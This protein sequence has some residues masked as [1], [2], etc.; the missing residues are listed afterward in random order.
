MTIKCDMFL[1]DIQL[2][3][4]NLEA[5]RKHFPIEIKSRVLIPDDETTEWQGEPDDLFLVELEMNS[6][7]HFWYMGQ[8]I[9]KIKYKNKALDI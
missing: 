4:K 2:I 7:N 6:M 5:F 9:G 8:L 1:E 3:H